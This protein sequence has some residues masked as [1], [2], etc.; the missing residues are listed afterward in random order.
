VI[1]YLS[2]VSIESLLHYGLNPWF[3]IIDDHLVSL[4]VAMI[5]ECLHWGFA[6]YKRIFVWLHCFQESLH[7]DTAIFM[8]FITK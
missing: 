4:V 6:L 5:K 3:I 8:F 7:V 1:F 2:F